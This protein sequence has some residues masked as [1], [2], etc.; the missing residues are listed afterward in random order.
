MVHTQITGGPLVPWRTHK[1][2]ELAAILMRRMRE[3]CNAWL[4]LA[5]HRSSPARTRARL[6]SLSGR[7]WRDH[8]L[9]RVPYSGDPARHETALDEA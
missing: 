8:T 2:K 9:I 5:A 6:P 4:K 7:R 1:G 3:P